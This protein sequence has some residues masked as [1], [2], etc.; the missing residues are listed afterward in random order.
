M[1]WAYRGKSSSWRSKMY[2]LTNDMFKCNHLISNYQQTLLATNWEYGWFISGNIH[3]H[4]A[5]S[6][7]DVVWGFTST[8][9]FYIDPPSPP[10]IAPS[11]TRITNSASKKPA[12]ALVEQQDAE[13][14]HKTLCQRKWS[15]PDSS[16]WEGVSRRPWTKLQ[17][18]QTDRSWLRRS[19]TAPRN[20]EW[21][22]PVNPDPEKPPLSKPKEEATLDTGG[23]RRQSS[24]N[25]NLALAEDKKSSCTISLC[26]FCIKSVFIRNWT[27]FCQ[28]KFMPQLNENEHQ[29][30]WHIMFRV[31]CHGTW[32]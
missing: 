18:I 11:P 6:R 2:W 21:W 31:T 30:R 26:V 1:L 7:Y 24:T 25:S 15:W 29:I 5:D 14:A 20:N 22:P 3:S 23:D 27:K 9:D 12:A 16:F 4:H 17:N 13:G 19:L 8:S 32:S 10:V 28:P